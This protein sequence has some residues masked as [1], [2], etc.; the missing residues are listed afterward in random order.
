MPGQNDAVTVDLF[1]HVE[2]F[3]VLGNAFG[4][5]LARSP[6]GEHTH[7][8]RIGNQQPGGQTGALHLIGHT[9]VGDAEI[10]RCQQRVIGRGVV[11]LVESRLN[12][13]RLLRIGVDVLAKHQERVDQLWVKVLQHNEAR[14]FGYGLGG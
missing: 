3:D 4:V 12:L 13:D 7:P 14:I 9:E 2:L 6:G 11:D 1:G 8:F 10:G 5:E